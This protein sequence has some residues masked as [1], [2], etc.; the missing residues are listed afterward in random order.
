GKAW[1]CNSLII[2]SNPLVASEKRMNSDRNSFSF[3]MHSINNDDII[4]DSNCKFS[5]EITYAKDSFDHG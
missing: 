5:L 3:L 4:K 2:G 1:D